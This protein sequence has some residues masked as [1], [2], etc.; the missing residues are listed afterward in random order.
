MK[1]GFGFMRIP[2][3]EEG[4]VNMELLNELV[5]CFMQ[6]GGT[7]FDTAYSYGKD[8]DSET[9]L[10]DAVVKRYPRSAYTVATKV[11]AGKAAGEEQAKEQFYTSLSRLETGWID[12]YLLHGVQIANVKRYEDWHLF[13]FLKE[14]KE[15]GLIRNI[16]FSF[17]SSPEMLDDLLRRHPETD[18]V[19]LQINYA[20]WNDP[21]I[22]SKKCYETAEKYGVKIMVME[23][24]KGGGLADPGPR[25]T[26]ILKDADSE[27]SC[28][29]W[30]LRFAASLDRVHTV[31]SGMNTME[32]MK[33]NLS[34]M[35]D[36]RPLS[37]AEY[38]VIEKAA[39]ALRE[40]NSIAC[41]GCRYCT[42][43]CPMN[44]SIPEVFA[45]MNEYLRYHDRLKFRRNYGIAVRKGSDASQCIQC[46]QCENACPQHLSIIQYL[47][48]TRNTLDEL[49]P[50]EK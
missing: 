40:E 10:R 44:I 29:S 14:K 17:H 39:D 1:L 12:Y 49:F 35:K 21:N 26:K 23:P 42:P 16:G 34:V 2:R 15:E 33:D 50:E 27:A 8:G 32:Q 28:A 20:D 6:N 30:A 19:Q 25:V 5:D 18:F 36:F 43:G 48:D 7:Y 13:E 4:S 38:R 46:G 45:S 22:N 11:N 9:S 24:V 37:E 47:R 3:L 41:T 31:L